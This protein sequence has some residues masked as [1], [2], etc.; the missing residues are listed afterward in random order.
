MSKENEKKE[1]ELSLRKAASYGIG[2]FSDTIASQMFTFLIFTFY[3]TII[4][5]DVLFITLGFIL[6]SIWNALNDPLLGTLS[7]RTKTKWG[8]RKPY[9]IAAIGPLCVLMILL[10]TPILATDISKFLYFLIIIILWELFYTMF[11]LNYASLFPEMFQD[12]NARAKANTI[13]Q[14]FTV[15]GLVFAFIMPTFFIPELTNPDYIANYSYAGIFMSICIAI[16]ALILIRFGSR[17]RV[18]FSEDYK[19]A[20]SLLNSLKFSIK[21]KGFRTFI[22]ANLCHWY[23]IGMLP[24]IVPLFGEFVLNES[25]STILGLLLGITF[26]SAAIFVFLWQYIVVKVG[27]KKGLMISM[28]TFA[29]TL[30]PFMFISDVTMGFIAFFIAGLGLSGDILYV[31]LVLAAVIDEDELNTGIRRE[32]GYYG[33]N[34]LIVKLSTIFVFLT[35]S[36]VFT[37]YGWRTFD[38]LGTTE[39]TIFGLRSLMFIFPAIALCI[40][41]LSMSRFPITKEKYEQIK[42]DVEKLHK[43]KIEKIEKI[44]NK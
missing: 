18:E 30:V 38:P 5:L 11:D 41:I 1:I 14:I 35:I 40:G 3:Y 20:P 15:I 21:N 34:A 26:I 19:T 2:Q 23:V 22:I 13:K 7:D 16:G 27:V 12:L 32:G 28:A 39:Q 31:D 4:G 10:W 24:T 37:S 43:E 36:I 8:R 42:L 33:I 6:W 29:I 25:D 44:T 9:I 17:E